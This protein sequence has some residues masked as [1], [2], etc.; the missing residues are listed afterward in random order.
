MRTILTALLACASLP[1]LAADPQFVRIQPDQASY[2]VGAKAIVF[3]Y[4]D[5]L[6]T[7]STKEFFVTMR[8]GGELTNAIRLSDRLLVA[9]PKRFEAAGKQTI[10][11]NV[12]LQT[13]AEQLQLAQAAAF[14]QKK[15]DALRKQLADERDPENRALLEAIIAKQQAKLREVQNQIEGQRTLVEVGQSTVLVTPSSSL[16]PASTFSLTADREPAEYLVG[17]SATFTA[18][19]N[20]LFTGPDGP[21]EVVLRGRIGEESVSAPVRSGDDFTFT[22][23]VFEASHAGERAFSV[24]YLV[25]SQTQSDVLRNA[26]RLA[27]K[28]K[29]D[30]EK[31]LEESVGPEEWPYFQAK[32][33]EMNQVVDAISM[34]LEEI[35][36]D[37]DEAILNF[38]VLSGG[39]K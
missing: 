4:V 22:S 11:S 36:V 31:K 39:R 25:R 8:V 33:I 24:N 9:L 23:P 5:R 21:K 19:L 20:T 27:I 7:E 17:E 3:A 18:H 14:Y 28:Q 15:I 30:F 13:K 12:F 16:K 38:T 34:Q 6:P 2:E 29:Q 10:E 37:I 32:A 26:L 1:A 35:L